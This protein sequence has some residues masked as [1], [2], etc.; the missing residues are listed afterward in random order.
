[1]R[2]ADAALIARGQRT[3]DL[4]RGDNIGLLGGSARHSI[5]VEGGWYGRGLGFRLTGAWRSGS[6]VRTGVSAL[7]FSSLA[8]INLRAF[9]NFD[10]RKALVK[11]VPFLKGSRIAVRVINLTDAIQTVRDGNGAVP[12]RYQAGY[13]DPLGRTFEISF[14][15]IF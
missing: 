10:Q 13:V 9:V 14:R 5:D 2:L 4:L 15:K 11:A 1:L 8:T 12:F 3:L 7:R 6:F